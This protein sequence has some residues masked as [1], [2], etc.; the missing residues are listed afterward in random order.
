MELK[1]RDAAGAREL[2]NALGLEELVVGG[3]LV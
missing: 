3:A 1:V 2:L